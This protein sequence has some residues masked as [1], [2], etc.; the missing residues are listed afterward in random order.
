M[1][2][3]STLRRRHRWALSLVICGG[4]LPV[5]A[6]ADQPSASPLALAALIAEGEGPID[7]GVQNQSA[8]VIP[9]SPIVVQEAVSGY[10]LD[11]LEQMALMNNPSIARIAAL[12][13]AAR[14]NAYQV[15]LPPNPET[16]Y[17]G[18]QIGSQGRAE[19]HGVVLNQELVV[20]EKL[21]LNRAVAYAE[22]RRLENEFAAQRQRVLTDVRVAF[23]Q[24]L[25]AQ[26]QLTVATEL[27]KISLQ[28]RDSANALFK[29][30]EVSKIDVLQAEIEVEN[31]AILKRNS[32]NR[33]FAANAALNAVLG[34]IDSSPIILIGDLQADLREVD[35]EMVLAQILQTSPEVSVVLAQLE[36]SRANLSRQVIEPRP[37][38]T[39]Q[40]LVNWRD[41]GI[42]GDPDGA[43]QLTMPIPIWNRNQGAIR[44]AR[45]QITAAE[46]ELNQVELDLQNRL[47][48]VYE[49]YSNAIEQVRR[50]NTSILPKAEETLSLT[51]EA[52]RQ[53]ELSFINL[54]TVQRT[55]A[56]SRI[57]YLDALESLRISEAR[58]EGLLLDGSLS[59]RP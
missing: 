26:Q 13:N 1:R 52:Y 6:K 24:A 9:P 5:S 7:A 53:G 38:V 19:Q 32:E 27:E 14:G 51:R 45:N 37:N 42:S 55:N 46:R 3:P 11:E 35:F 8:E 15:G 10:R 57:A 44:E 48:P 41:N 28:A 59:N 50:F 54:L 2:N 43:L 31:A 39:V 47:A 30:S 58:M 56:Q 17:S 49:Q 40:G 21:R 12:V 18:Q 22:V 33:V 16:G 29:A 25:R 4:M 36:R 34:R 20:R 23:I